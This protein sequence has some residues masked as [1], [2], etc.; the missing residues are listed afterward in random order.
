[1]VKP[2]SF[3]SCPAIPWTNTTGK[4]TA[5]VVVVE[6]VMAEATSWAPT[7]AAFRMAYRS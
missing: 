2:N 3:K 5:M 1:M 6:A 4:K 7:S